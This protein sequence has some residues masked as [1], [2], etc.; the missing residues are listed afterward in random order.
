M[1]YQKHVLQLLNKVKE[2]MFVN[3]YIKEREKDMAF[4]FYSW[5]PL[6]CEKHVLEI[7]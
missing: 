5:I 1:K 3:I 7:I 6:T 4:F 2:S